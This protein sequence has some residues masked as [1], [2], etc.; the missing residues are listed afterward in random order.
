MFECNHVIVCLVEKAGSSLFIGNKAAIKKASSWVGI[1]LYTLPWLLVL[2]LGEGTCCCGGPCVVL[3]W[4]PSGV[5]VK[6][7]LWTLCGH[8]AWPH[9]AFAYLLL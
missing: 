2:L 5:Q 7:F 1:R 8:W 3:V 6:A 4:L 9:V